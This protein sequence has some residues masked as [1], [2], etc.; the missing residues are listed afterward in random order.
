MSAE[1]VS[2]SSVKIQ[3]VNVCTKILLLQ[4][5][6]YITQQG[7]EMAGGM[8]IPQ[9]QPSL[10]FDGQNVFRIKRNVKTLRIDFGY[11]ITVV[12]VYTKI[13]SLSGM[14]QDK[15]A[16]LKALYFQNN[17][18]KMNKDL[19]EYSISASTNGSE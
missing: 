10:V 9:D 14:T 13:I 19:V 7:C 11:P 3:L 17:H 15:E 1:S 4:K 6:S 12:S 8:V 18:L 2:T 16:A 5:G